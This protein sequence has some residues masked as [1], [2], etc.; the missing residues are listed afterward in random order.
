MPNAPFNAN[1]S[2][3]K[4]LIATQSNI[5]TIQANQQ[6][7]V[8]MANRQGITIDNAIATRLKYG[9]GSP[10]DV[11]LLLS[12]GVESGALPPDQQALQRWAD[13]NLALDC[14]G[15]ESASL[16]EI[17]ALFWNETMTRAA[18]VSW[19]YPNNPRQKCEH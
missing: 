9:K 12:R 14:P 8:S 6:R 15:L 16:G 10:E 11:E 5:A 17:A 1:V 4:Y 13:A 19:C 3:N 18:I 7:I 2:V